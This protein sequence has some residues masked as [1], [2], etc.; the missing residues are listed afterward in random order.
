LKDLVNRSFESGVFPDILKLTKYVPIPKKNGCILLND[1]RPIALTSV[2]CKIFERVIFE[3]ITNFLTKYNIMSDSQHAYRTS[4]SCDTAT[5]NL[6]NIINA[7]LSDNRKTCILFLDL[8]KAFDTV[9]LN[10]LIDKIEGYGLRGKISD[11]LKSY[12]LNRRQYVEVRDGKGRVIKSSEMKAYNG[13]PQGSTLG[14]F[15]L[16]FILMIFQLI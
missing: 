7:K 4:R 11:L 10:L 8:S 5:F 3:R 12:S 14:P 1:L 15:C 16:I 9:S 2:F 13:V 6:T